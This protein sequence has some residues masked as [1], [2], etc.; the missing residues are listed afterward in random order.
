V[1]AESEEM[2]DAT[3]WSGGRASVPHD[4]RIVTVLF[5]DVVRSTELISPMDAEAAVGVLLPLVE[6]MSKSVARYGGTITHRLGDGLMGVFGVPVIQEDHAIRACH[7]ALAILSQTEQAA[8]DFSRKYSVPIQVRIGLNSGPVILTTTS[9]SGHVSYDALGPTTHLAARME[10]VADPGTIVISD[11][12]ARLVRD[13]FECRLIG[14]KSVKGFKEQ[15]TVYRLIGPLLKPGAGRKDRTSHIRSPMVGRAL[16]M[17]KLLTRLQALAHGKGSFVSVS[18]EP[19]VGKSRLLE[20]ARSSL[21]PH[22]VWLEGHA[23][24]FGQRLSYWPFIEM[25]K[26]WLG[27]QEAADDS[28]TWRQT[29]RKI[30]EA[31]GEQGLEFLPYIA[32]MLGLEVREPY[33]D[34]I[35]RLDAENLGS[36]IMRASWRLFQS[37]ARKTPVVIVIEDLHWA[38]R[39]SAALLEH[40]LSLAGETSLLICVTSRP[41]GDTLKRLEIAA[42]K[43]AG[44]DVTQLSLLPLPVDDCQ[45]LIGNILGGSTETSRIRDMILYRAEGNP[46][47]AEELIKDLIDSQ[48]LVFEESEWRAHD[49]HVAL[50]DTVDGVIM[51]RIDRLD[52]RLKQVLATASVIGRR[53]LFRV[54]QAVTE[55]S[56]DLVERLS[57]LKAVE[58]IDEVKSVPELA[59]LFHH[60]LVQEAVY[61]SILIERRKSIHE[62]VA[63]FLEALYGDHAHEAASLLAFHYARAE[64]YEKALKYLLLAAEQSNRMAADDEALLHYEEAVQA[65]GRVFGQKWDQAQ[66]AAIEYRLGEI[67]LRRSNHSQ[68]VAHLSNALS[69]CG[70]RIP[71]SKAA[72]ALVIFREALAQIAHRLVPTR[73]RRKPSPTIDPAYLTMV[74]AHEALAWAMS[75]SDHLKTT[76]IAFKMLNFSEKSAIG[77]GIAKGSAGFGWGLD[78]FGLHRLA[79]FY[80]RRAVAVAQE[81]DNPSALGLA[82]NLL[83]T[84]NYLVG[85]WAE[86]VD[87]FNKSRESLNQAGDLVAW[88][89]ASAQKCV[90]LSDIGAFSEVLET[91]AQLTALGRESG[92]P[93]AYRYGLAMRA[94]ACRRLGRLH[95]CEP[96]FEEA[97]KLT[98]QNSDFLSLG[99]ILG[100]LAYFR[101]QQGRLDEAG[102]LL[103]TCQRVYHDHPILTH[104]R[105]CPE[106][107]KALLAIRSWEQSAHRGPVDDRHMLRSCKEAY[108]SSRIFRNGLPAAARLLGTANWLLDR[109]GKARRWWQESLDTAE[110][111]GAKYHAGLTSI[112]RGRRSDSADDL[113]RGESLLADLGVEIDGADK[114][115]LV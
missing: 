38:D 35:L 60:A 115:P 57:K 89:N 93:T 52:D 71:D 79:S 50:P 48:A 114:F 102:I 41:E 13:M 49:E 104:T 4:R 83:A 112:E 17:D 84:H 70:Q 29:E 58:I 106:I 34:Q 30:V 3:G 8:A 82:S 36:Q 28:K 6:A 77:E 105:V 69:Y 15:H 66:R 81:L 12:T 92:L 110:R 113:E 67:H 11:H 59:Y 51:A 43:V 68:A 74:R 109:P 53:F 46:F 21:E 54:L 75:M 45:E 27:I 32:V 100:E 101:I 90:V 14:K 103:G 78:C 1:P 44:L 22:V 23:I 107:A 97:V 7:A 24:S 111:Y 61:E 62:R 86:A 25:L 33:I 9:D 64:N 91:A 99:H 63:D 10:T 80:H 108:R 19:G 85:R 16:E 55:Q 73:A 95:E 18:G 56:D 87:R 42:G 47:F 98:L 2:K 96:M 37:I 72:A 94:V 39:S 65:Y 31:M 40:L 76:A 88:T 5:A 20:E 26:P